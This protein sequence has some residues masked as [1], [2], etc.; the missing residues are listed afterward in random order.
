M[1]HDQFDPYH[2]SNSQ[3][4]PKNSQEYTYIHGIGFSP[5]LGVMR[6]KKALR[7][8]ANAIGIAMLAYL[9]LTYLV[10]D[11][12]SLAST[13]LLPSI[14]GSFFSQTFYQI[15]GILS[16]II[17]MGLPFFI[18]A[19]SIRIP[20]RRALPL[21]MPPLSLLIPSIFLTFGATAVASFASGILQNLLY[22]LGI[23]APGN[24]GELPTTTAS[25]TVVYLISSTLL[26]AVLEEFVF[27]GVLMQSLRR[28]GDAMAVVV[29]AVLFAA[30]HGNIIVFPLAL[31][32]GLCSGY[33]VIRMGSL[34]PSILFHFLYNSLSIGLNEAYIRLPQNISLLLSSA[35]TLAQLL[36]AVLSLIYLMKT[37]TGIFSLKPAQTTLNESA[38]LKTFF[39]SVAIIVVLCLFALLAITNLYAY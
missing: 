4:S 10:P 12:I 7:R 25:A 19:V 33:F 20:V 24:L 35:L 22:F 1:Y 11:V 13:I 16:T 34:W 31:T 27:R 39:S 8:C 6:E 28:F 3:A 36:L 2:T 23:Y 26:P 15:L 38:K 30:A 18:Y 21:Q 32:M 9:A 5:L 17:S 29:S 14:Y 37:R